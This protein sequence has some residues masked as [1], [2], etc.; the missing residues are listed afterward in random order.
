[1]WK[2]QRETETLPSTCSE[3][4]QTHFLRH[5]KGKSERGRGRKKSLLTDFHALEGGVALAVTSTGDIGG[6]GV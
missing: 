3:A 2:E 4:S 5:L 1:M 6:G